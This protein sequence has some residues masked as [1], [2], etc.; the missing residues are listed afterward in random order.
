ML[1]GGEYAVGEA[2]PGQYGGLDASYGD[3]GAG[4][5]AG[6]VLLV[7]RLADT[8]GGRPAGLGYGLETRLGRTAAR[9]RAAIDGLLMEAALPLPE[10]A[11]ART[12]HQSGQQRH[13]GPSYRSLSYHAWSLLVRGQPHKSLAAT[14][15]GVRGVAIT[16]MG[17]R[18][19]SRALQRN[20]DPNGSADVC[21]FHARKAETNL[22][23]QV[24][25]CPGF[26]TVLF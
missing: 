10:G 17:R 4:P 7:A 1:H 21:S 25:T 26:R 14:C 23:P 13:R 8:A 24:S 19:K 6:N 11:A 9:R 22:S 12:R 16:R 20:A 15:G 2:S 5:P 3:A 18:V